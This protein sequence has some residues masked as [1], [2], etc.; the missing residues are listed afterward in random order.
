MHAISN[1]GKSTDIHLCIY[2]VYYQEQYRSFDDGAFITRL[3][4][5]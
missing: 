4:N 2:F 3:I 1:K 5:C